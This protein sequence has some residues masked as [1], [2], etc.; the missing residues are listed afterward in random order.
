MLKVLEP[1]FIENTLTAVIRKEE[2]DDKV[3]RLVQRS[4][5]TYQY[6]AIDGYALLNYRA[7]LLRYY[8]GEDWQHEISERMMAEMIH[9]DLIEMETLENLPE[10]FVNC[11]ASMGDNEEIYHFTI[12]IEE[13]KM[14]DDNG[15]TVKFNIPEVESR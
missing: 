4:R 13:M 3:P 9:D 5:Y 10:R 2:V 8:F 15:V 11:H 12:A 6:W 14:D 1:T 7:S